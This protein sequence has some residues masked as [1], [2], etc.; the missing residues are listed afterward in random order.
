MAEQGRLAGLFDSFDRLSTREKAMVGGLLGAFGLTGLIIVWLIVG[1]QI[2]DLEQRNLNMRTALA[3][4]NTLKEPYL[5]AK[6]KL[7]ANKALLD[8]NSV[9]LVKEMEQQASRLE[10]TINDFK[11]AKRFLTE[12]HRRAKKGTKK[13]ITDLV[14]ESQTVSI[15]DITLDQLSRFMAALESRPE[16]ILVTRLNIN[17]RSS[18]RQKLREVRMTVSTYRNEEVT[19]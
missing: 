12:N 14:E 9:K 8:N 18:D 2:N 6:A 10:I 7:D 16:P 3:Q 17:T 1:N 19:P 13:K 4:V 11:E 5:R 15:R